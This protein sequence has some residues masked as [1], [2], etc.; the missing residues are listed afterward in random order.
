M[1]LNPS[2]KGKEIEGLALAIHELVNRLPLTMRTQNEYGVRIE[3]GEV[4][5]YNYTG[6]LLEKVLKDG[7]IS[8]DIPESGPY[9]GTPV[10]VVPILDNNEIIAVVGVVDITKGIYSDIM[11]ITKRPQDEGRD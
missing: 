10:M 8:R 11:Q 4:L 2:S 6:T 1:K 5:D 3:D 7:E 9:K